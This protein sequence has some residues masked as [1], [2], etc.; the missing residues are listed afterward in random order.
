MKP[1]VSGILSNLIVLAEEFVTKPQA[2]LGSSRLAENLAAIGEDVRAADDGMQEGG[3]TTSSGVVM[4]TALEQYL[5][6]PEP[7]RGMWLII[8]GAT[9][10]LLRAETF[11]ALANERTA[12]ASS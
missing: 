12:R 1:S 5:L 4:V 3:P 8:A 11:K 2:A 6:M 10:P 7:L 9:L